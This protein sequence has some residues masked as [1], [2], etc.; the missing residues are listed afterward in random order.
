MAGREGMTR[1][2]V[3]NALDIIQ[4]CR[5]PQHP[6]PRNLLKGVRAMG[7]AEIY[8][9]PGLWER[10]VYR[11]LYRAHA[12]SAC[13]RP[14]D[15]SIPALP[16]FMPIEVPIAV[17]FIQRPGIQEMRISPIF[18]PDEGTT[19]IIRERIVKTVGSLSPNDLVGC[20]PDAAIPELVGWHLGL[21]RNCPRPN[22]IEL[23][24]IYRFQII[25]G[26]AY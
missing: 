22:P 21:H 14:G 26:P 2:A 11:E 1:I 12:I 19:V 4:G 8:G 7:R 6:Q 13:V 16:T 20:S 9:T 15:R 5:P 17:R 10:V 25:K 23:V 24:T 3:E 18:T